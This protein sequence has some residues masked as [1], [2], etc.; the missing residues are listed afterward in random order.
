MRIMHVGTREINESTGLTSSL[1]Y[2]ISRSFRSS[3]ALLIGFRLNA[4]WYCIT[5]ASNESLG[6]CTSFKNYFIPFII[7][8]PIHP[9]GRSISYL[10][11][12]R[13]GK[14]DLMKRI[15][16]IPQSKYVPLFI[17]DYASMCIFFVIFTICETAVVIRSTLIHALSTLVNAIKF[18][19]SSITSSL[20]VLATFK[21]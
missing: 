4:I 21:W 9:A 13:V 14:Q 6:S 8:F 1:L 3:T 15:A 10:F 19:R 18:S 11:C 20:V 2:R 12:D 5:C 16:L 17:E 7:S